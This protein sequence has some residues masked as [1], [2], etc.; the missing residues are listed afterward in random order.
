MLY[1]TPRLDSDDERVIRE[2][3]GYRERFRHHL[4]EPARWTGQMRRSLVAAAIRGSNT[5]EGYSISGDDAI[6]LASGEELSADVSEDTEAAVV[7]YKLALTYIQQSASFPIF[8]YDHSLMSALHFMITHHDLH[9]SPGRYRE[10]DVWVTGG[11]GQPPIYTAPGA[12]LV[13]DLMTELFSWLNGGDEDAPTY[14]R[15]AMAHLNLVG[16]HPWRDGN[17]RMS[18]AVHTLVLARQ[19]VLA[20]EFS[21]V[22]E[23][24][25]LSELNTLSYYGA[26]HEVQRGSWSPR[27]DAH[28]WVRF[29]LRAHHLQAQEIDRRIQ[30][31]ARLWTELSAVA[32]ER[33]LPERVISALFAAARGHLRRVTYGGDEGLSRDQAVRDL[34]LLKRLRLID[35]IGHGRTQRYVAAREVADIAAEMRSA[36]FAEFLREPYPDSGGDGPDTEV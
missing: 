32:A 24:L 30:E 21:S 4:A 11:P 16:I 29:C 2:L 17:G 8:A 14:V 7:G 26:L 12:E 18:R 3:R 9:R 19:R 13:P 25:G 35:P 6:A 15:A 34:Q 1:G 27:R 31:S 20:P 10:G 28:S 33:G 5:I 36:T 22:E 23:W